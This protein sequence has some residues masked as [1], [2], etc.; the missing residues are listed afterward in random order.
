MKRLLVASF[1]VTLGGCPGGGELEQPGKYFP[2]AGGMGSVGSGGTGGTAG[3][4][5]LV[6]GCDYAAALATC[7]TKFCHLPGATPVLAGLNLAPDDGLVS[8][9]KDVPATFGDLYCD[10]MP[11]ATIPDA[12]PK[13]A[14]LVD[15]QDFSRSLLLRK[16]NDPMDC[17]DKMPP[18]GYQYTDDE[19]ACL[20]TMVQAIADLP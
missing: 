12:C 5:A 15:S 11:C 14:L 20:T 3:G 7:A 9:L 6:V 17:G 16:L 2:E 8:R 18:P 1:L 19:R 13:G 4:S 10:N